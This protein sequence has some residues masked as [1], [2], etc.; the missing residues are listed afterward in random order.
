MARVYDGRTLAV[1]IPQFPSQTH[2]FFWNEIRY[3]ESLGIEVHLFS[4]RHPIKSLVSHG[5]SDEAAARTTYLGTGSV[6]DKI[7]AG[8]RLPKSLAAL[9]RHGLD[10]GSVKS[11]LMS[12]PA[13]R[14]LW[15]ACAERGI[16]HIHAHSAANSAMIAALCKLTG[17]PDYSVTLH[18]PMEDYGPAQAFKWAGARFGIVITEV[19][20]QQMSDRIGA[21]VPADLHVCPMGVDTDMFKPGAPYTPWT[22]EGPFRLFCCARL[23][24][25]KGH[26]IALAAMARVQ[27][28][29]VP[30]H[31]TIA[32]EDDDGGQGY[33][34]VLEAAIQQSPVKDQV[35]LLGAVGSDVVVTH[36][37]SAHGFVLA[38]HAEPLGVAYMEAMA[39][40]CPTI[41]T[42]AGGV[43]ELITDGQDGL[44]VPPQD[45]D[46]LAEAILKIAKD[47]GLAQR[48]SEAGRARILQAFHMRRSA[49]V[50]AEAGF[51]PPA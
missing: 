30:V 37:Q 13:A 11:L 5:W 20:K 18:G 49:Q 19:L 32:G 44:M 23:N 26:E 28:R 31:L 4:T 22:G 10:G 16:T 29:G 1:L 17:G 47:P 33:R 41:G 45:A 14:A 3:L 36:L 25:V 12:A 21:A 8:L 39:C 9:A 50:I 43:P 35:T 46:A 38:S 15:Q 48:L 2:A 51:G 7:G 34:T 24:W 27:A 6:P 40:G 42:R